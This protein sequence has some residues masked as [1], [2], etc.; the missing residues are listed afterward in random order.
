MVPKLCALNM[1]RMSDQLALNCEPNATPTTS[2]TITATM[3]ACLELMPLAISTTSP[4]MRTVEPS[5][6]AGRAW[7]ASV[8]DRKPTAATS[9]A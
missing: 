7:M 2:A 8:A 9:S 4:W 6:S 1:S 5:A 3:R